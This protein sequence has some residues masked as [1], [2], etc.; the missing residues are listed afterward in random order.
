MSLYPKLIIFNLLPFLLFLII[1]GTKPVQAQYIAPDS[2]NNVVVT[3]SH[4]SV[5]Q[6]LW[7]SLI[8]SAIV[9]GLGQ[10]RQENPGRAVIFYGASLSLLFN[11][12]DNYRDYDDTG[13]QDSRAA[14]YASLALLSQVYLVNILDVLDTY[15]RDKYEPWPQEL[16]S[17][18]PMKSPW[19]AVA[20]SAMLPGWG[21]AYNEQ[22]IKAIIGFGAFTYFASRVYHL[23][24]EY[25]KTGDPGF[26][27]KRVTNSWYLG[28]TYMIIMV[29]AYVGAYL[30]RF[31]D[32]MEITLNVVPE[33]KSF[34]VNLGVA[35]VF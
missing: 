14:A 8:A 7:P 10:I 11:A 29:D 5:K 21:Q 2:L 32:A 12:I 30:Y 17:D 1:I 27:D 16:Y 3:S 13:N 33:D 6:S 22:Y 31:D 15:L 25:K 24:Q 23:N 20:R 26:R 4:D 34:A 19:G 18:I 35:I 9:P 28:L